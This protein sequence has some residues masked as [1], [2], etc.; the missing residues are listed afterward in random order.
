[1]RWYENREISRKAE[2]VA[3]KTYV[4][5][6]EKRA[7]HKGVEWALEKF[8]DMVTE[9]PM[10][11]EQSTKKLCDEFRLKDFKQMVDKLIAAKK[12]DANVPGDE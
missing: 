12:R 8:I 9:H 11:Y 6:G 4:H 7:F 3:T 2:K 10:E 5:E 1:M